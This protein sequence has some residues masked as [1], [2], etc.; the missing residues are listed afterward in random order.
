MWIIFGKIGV[1]WKTKKK[2]QGSLSFSINQDENFDITNID[3]TKIYKAKGS[4][5]KRIGDGYTCKKYN[6]DLELKFQ[7]KSDMNIELKITTMSN[8]YHQIIDQLYSKIKI[9]K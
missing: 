9:K 6:K 3:Y 5:L 8:F 7:V 1:F 2:C 4:Y